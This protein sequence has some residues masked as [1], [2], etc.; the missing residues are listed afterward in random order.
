MGIIWRD[1]TLALH[2]EA[3]KAGGQKGGRGGDEAEAE[4]GGGPHEDGEALWR[5]HQRS[6]E[7]KAILPIGVRLHREL[8]TFYNIVYK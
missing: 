1:L 8:K 3:P 4:G 7:E 5:T 2:Q 6:E